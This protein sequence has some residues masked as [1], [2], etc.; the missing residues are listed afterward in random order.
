[1]SLC[2]EKGK[3]IAAELLNP[4]ET[5][6][7]CLRRVYGDGSARIVRHGYYLLQGIYRSEDV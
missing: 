4:R 6:A 2:A 5:V 1:M 7:H 3:K